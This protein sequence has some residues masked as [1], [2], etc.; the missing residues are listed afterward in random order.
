[1]ILYF[2]DVPAQARAWVGPIP[3][4]N[5]ARTLA[6][7][8]ASNVSGETIRAAIRDI[9]RRGLLHPSDVTPVEGAPFK[10]E[11]RAARGSRAKFDAVLSKV[12][13]A[14]PLKGDELAA[15][16]PTKAGGKAAR[17]TGR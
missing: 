10:R 7:C 8:V 4:T 17:R 11:T 5:V 2:A 15:N 1:V 3:V 16:V 9:N 12:C 14:P 6:D 13:D